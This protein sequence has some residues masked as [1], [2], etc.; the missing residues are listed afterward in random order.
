MALKKKKKKHKPRKM[1]KG[2]GRTY[3]NGRTMLSKKNKK[4]CAIRKKDNKWLGCKD[5]EPA[6]ARLLGRRAA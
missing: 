6:A 2:K 4:F 5:T 3:K 1:P